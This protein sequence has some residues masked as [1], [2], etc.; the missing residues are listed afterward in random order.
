MNL[1]QPSELAK[2]TKKVIHHS[3]QPFASI[4][5]PKVP[6]KLSP[7]FLITIFCR[8]LMPSSRLLPGPSIQSFP[9]QVCQFEEKQFQSFVDPVPLI[10]QDKDNIYHLLQIVWQPPSNSNS[11]SLQQRLTCV[12]QSPR[13]TSEGRSHLKLPQRK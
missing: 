12:C 3:Y 8:H 13:P 1:N 6:K 7:F 9:I 10:I 11:S 4:A 5:K 2:S